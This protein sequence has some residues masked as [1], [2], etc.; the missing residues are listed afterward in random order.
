MPKQS[1]FSQRSIWQHILPQNA[2]ARIAIVVGC[3]YFVYWRLF[4][5]TWV[6]PNYLNYSGSDGVAA[7]KHVTVT[8]SLSAIKKVWETYG[9]EEPYYSVLTQD[10]Y[11]MNNINEQSLKKFYASGS[12][13]ATRIKQLV[14]QTGVKLNT[15]GRALD[16]G[17][18]V[19][20]ITV[21]LADLFDKVVGCDISTKH[22]AL[23]ENYVSHTPLSDRVSF[24]VSGASLAP[25][26]EFDFV[27]TVIVLQHMIP[28]LQQDMIAQFCKILKPSGVAMFHIPTYHPEYQ[29]RED[30]GITKSTMMKVMMTHATPK[31]TVERIVAEN[32]CR[33]VSA[34][35]EN[36]VGD[37]WQSHIFVIQKS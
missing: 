16:F 10:E 24:V 15:K 18:G 25:L 33:V 17:C 27:Y 34:I 23:A 3:L 2:A 36:M 20:R 37:N 5:Y 14:A 7:N 1:A 4:V 12:T 8:D 35:P 30:V 13:E 26:G 31:L 9:I 29:W 32:G 11:L 28:P 6:D 19:G 22:I 21:H